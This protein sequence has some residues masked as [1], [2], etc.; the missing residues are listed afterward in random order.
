MPWTGSRKATIEESFERMTEKTAGCWIWHGVRNHKGYGNLRGKMAHRVSYEIY[1][2]KIPRGLQ[3]D[4]LCMVKHCV[5]P[6]HLEPVTNQENKR[7]WAASLTHC[8]QGHPYSGDNLR[9]Y[10]GT[11]RCRKC[12]TDRQR[13]WVT[14][15][16][17]KVRAYHRK[18]QR[19]LRSQA[20]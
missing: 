10:Q 3:L 15:N 6:A 20:C 13:S 7:R 16:R 4:H 2:G 9:I 14:K 1:K 12:M 18:Y 11:K 19:K 8:P 17:E 5:N